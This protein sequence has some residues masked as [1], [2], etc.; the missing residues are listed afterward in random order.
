LLWFSYLLLMDVQSMIKSEINFIKLMNSK[1]RMII[2]KYGLF[3][4]ISCWFFFFCSHSLKNFKSGQILVI[5][6][7]IICGVFLMQFL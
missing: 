7:C 4:S 6:L 2:I 3:Y 1:K 5:L